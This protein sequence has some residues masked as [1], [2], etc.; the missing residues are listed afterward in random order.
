MIDFVRVVIV[1]LRTDCMSQYLICSNL[2]NTPTDVDKSAI[3]TKT[4]LKETVKCL[5]TC[6]YLRIGKDLHKLNNNE[7]HGNSLVEASITSG[8]ECHIDD[9]L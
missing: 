4:V 9:L 7:F 6:T 2:T 3:G 8:Q 5:I 1:R